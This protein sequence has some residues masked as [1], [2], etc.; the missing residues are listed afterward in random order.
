MR[1]ALPLLCLLASP[2]CAED[3]MVVK[4]VYSQLV[5]LPM[6][7]NFV[8]GTDEDKDGYYIMDYAPKGETMD[9]WT[10][11][12][13]LGGAKDEAP[14]KSVADIA[15]ELA[16]TYKEACPATFSTKTLPTPKV[17]GASEVFSGYLG[18]GDAGGQSEAMVFLVLKGR[19]E[20]YTVEWAEHR[21]GQARPT[22][23][24]PAVWGPRSDAL[25][26][27]RICDKVPG[28]KA[29]YPSCTW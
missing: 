3:L 2:V 8:A 5:A 13:S 1:Y 25:A 7:A 10:Q 17:H 6:P 12:I 9:V 21:P 24:D 15:A 28:E 23:P 26:H 14:L 20:I 4:P 16:V 11:L 19:S 27:I 29:P 18:C 22:A